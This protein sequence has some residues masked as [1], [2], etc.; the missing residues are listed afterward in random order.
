M[1]EPITLA[2]LERLDADIE[3][4]DRRIDEL[5]AEV[6]LYIAASIE[7]CETRRQA[8]AAYRLQAARPLTS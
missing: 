3:A 2:D 5:R 7:L 8:A 6:R 4:M 1:T